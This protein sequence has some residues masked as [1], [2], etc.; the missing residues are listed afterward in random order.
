MSADI[1]VSVL[2]LEEDADLGPGVDDAEPSGEYGLS[3]QSVTPPLAEELGFE[4]GTKGVVVTRVRPGSP[5][6]KA[7]LRPR[8][9][10]L[11]VNQEPVATSA[12][13]RA[14]VLKNPR[15]AL[16]LV[17]RGKQ[18]VFITLKRDSR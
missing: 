5:A 12:A 9:L 18:E 14:A 16:L 13:F 11:E 17:R 3:V 6:E 15:G 8:D 2:A 7:T 4:A 10:I 1:V